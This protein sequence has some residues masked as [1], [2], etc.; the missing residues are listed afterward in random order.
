MRVLAIYY[1]SFIMQEEKKDVGLLAGG[2]GD[3]RPKISL[4]ID[5]LSYSGLTQLLRNPLIFKL[6]QILGVY[7]SNVSM[8]AMIGRAGHEALK[9][10]NG[11]NKDRPRLADPVENRAEAIA[12]GL[13][14]FET[15]DDSYIKY[16][17]TGSREKMMEGYTQAMNIY[18]EEEPVYNDIIICEEKLEAE[19]KNR[20]GQVFPLPAIAV[21]DVVD[22]CADDTY[23]I[24]DTKFVKSFTPHETEDGEPYEDYIK[25]V[26]AKFLDYTLKAAKGI[27]AKRVVFREI[28][29]SRSKDGGNQLRDYVV[30]LD[31]E[32]YD[33]IFIN[34]YADVVKFIS[35]PESIY[36][37]NLADN[38]DGE[39]A[40]LLYAQGLLS[41]DMSDIEVMHKVKD[42]AL[43][44]KKFVTSRLDQVH[45][46]HLLPEEK[47]KLR[48][49]E[50]GIPVQPVETKVGNSVTQYRFKVSA[51]I[52]MGRFKK[53]K[54]DIAR[55]IEAK[56]E[57][58]ILAPIPGTT[59]VGIEV[60]SE[61][62][63]SVTLSKE[64]FTQNTLNIPIGVDVHGNAVVLPLNEM[65]HLLIAG[66]TGSGKSVV[67]HSILTSLTKQNK[68]EALDLTLI[69]PKRVELV[70]F[71]NSKH[72]KTKKKILYEYD[73][74]I[75]AL[76]GLVD[77]MEVRYKTLEAT[78]V[79]DIGEYN[80][81]SGGVKGKM[82][83]KVTVIDEFADL[84]LK[85]KVEEKKKSMAYASKS[86]KWL[87]KELLKRADGRGYVNI[88]DENKE[89][90][91]VKIYPIT[92]YQKDDLID[93]LDAL[94]LQ[95][96]L[97][98]GDANIEMLVVRLAQM[99]RAVGIHLIVA[100][101]RPSVDVITGLIKANFP[102]RI[103]LTTSSPT[104]S[105][106]I[107]GEPGA[108]KLTGKGDMLL[109]SPALPTRVRLQGF[110]ISK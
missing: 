18:F 12:I 83:Y 73:D 95:N 90:K 10:Y 108:E 91:R 96:E 3:A 65:P 74:I 101:Q 67:L 68:P 28:K 20:A 88:E 27:Q 80:M 54:D 37:P 70:A 87:F 29:R 39:Q 8:S 79:R 107:L 38:F 45:N 105:I 2:G 63:T 100:T 94:D 24:I 33:I 7:D 42:V 49:A 51:G 5:K 81:I 85:S 1:L 21:P 61:V 103:A 62:R 32:P 34:L 15:V 97:K 35:N 75:L 44:S 30:P 84:I 64:H 56:G 102:T 41:A 43:V 86:K 11:G 14:Y 23:D 57:I 60:P 25:I 52:S 26:Q 31:H 93:L 50:F 98:R 6:K 53:H 19:I 47:I 109:M 9:F 71:K 36:L 89:M 40:G 46:Q 76:L 106:V 69:D 72:V 13:E 16:G 59:L 92:S 82:T 58:R 77:E 48:L 17:K 4:P 104:D 55:A 78:S 99:G 66:A 110:M 22:H